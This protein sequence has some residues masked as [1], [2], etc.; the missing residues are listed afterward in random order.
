MQRRQHHAQRDRA[1]VRV[2]DDPG[3]LSGSLAVHLRDDERNA[4]LQPKRGRLVDAERSAAARHGGR[5]RGSRI[6]AD[7]EEADIEVAGAECLR[8]GFLD[9]EIAEALSGGPR[10][11]ERTDDSCPRSRR[12]W[13]V[14]RPTAPVA[15]TTPIRT[16]SP[17]AT[18]T[19]ECR[20]EGR[21]AREK[22][23]TK[24][25]NRLTRRPAGSVGA[26][27]EASPPD[28]SPDRERKLANCGKNRPSS[29]L[30]P[31]GECPVPGSPRR[32]TPGRRRP[33]ARWQAA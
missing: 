8:R 5:A 24:T 14:T 1:A 30:A 27:Y 18:D 4:F 22:D 3:V 20:D 25:L 15:P 17:S 11:R 16:S 21:C 28:A 10:G 9:H 29:H 23:P 6:G 12:S 26:P 13:S 19:R 7:R 32:R 2:G 33:G 31:T